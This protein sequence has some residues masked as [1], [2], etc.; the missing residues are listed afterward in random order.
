MKEEAI[1]LKLHGYN[2]LNSMNQLSIIIV[3]YN[4][5]KLIF[6]CLNSIFKFNDIED[7]LE[8][9]IVDNG[10]SDQARMFYDVSKTFGTKVK[11]IDSGGNLGYGRGNNIGISHTSADV[12]VVMNP[13]VRIVEPIFSKLYDSFT[14]LSIGLIGVSFVDGSSPYYFKPEYRRIYN[15]LFFRFYCKRNRFDAI[16]MYMS[17]SF[18]AFRRKAFYE[19]GTFDENIFM[20][21]EEADISNRILA[22]GYK[23]VWRPEFYV[24]HLPHSIDFNKTL[25]DYGTRSFLY[26]CKKYNINVN[27]AYKREIFVLKIKY[28]ISCMIGSK[29]KRISFKNRLEY[30][31]E[32]FKKISN[33][34]LSN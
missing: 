22:S 32:T 9:I 5:Y 33:E 11:L 1:I 12:V 6:D 30:E 17:G 23:V 14:D 26:Y 2:K 21:S 27:T 15:Q 16:K 24:Q 4:S 8:V 3:T 13:D 19:A 29:Q 34:N 20:Y 10:S 28:L 31:M 25:Q 7:R 18:L